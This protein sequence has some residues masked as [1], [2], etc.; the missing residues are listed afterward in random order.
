[1][2]LTR[3]DIIDLN[4]GLHAVGNLSGFKFAYAIARNIN[5]LKSHMDEIRE[6]HKV[7]L[8]YNSF[9]KERVKIAEEHAVTENGK[10]KTTMKN[11]TPGYIIKDQKGF[12]KDLE[13]LKEKYKDAIEAREKQKIALEKFLKE[14]V[15]VDLYTIPTEYVPDAI[16]A[17][18]MVGVLPIVDEKLSLT[19]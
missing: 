1:M 6:M 18:Q 7:D 8:E 5:K 14:S 19:N 12:D 11:G 15:E 4:N 3:Q 16:T 2:K 13:V 10:P 9:E 17:Q